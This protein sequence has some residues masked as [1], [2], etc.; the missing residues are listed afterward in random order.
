MNLHFKC[1]VLCY[2]VACENEII[3]LKLW[4][5]IKKKR[6]FEGLNPPFSIPDSQKFQRLI[7]EFQVKTVN[8]TL[9]DTLRGPFQIL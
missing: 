6:F 5:K 9:S 4:I 1:F 2:C 3:S 8:L 7:I